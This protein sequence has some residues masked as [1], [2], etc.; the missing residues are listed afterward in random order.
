MKC[1]TSNIRIVFGSGCS[2]NFWL[3]P[4]YGPP[5]VNIIQDNDD[6][7]THILVLDFLHIGILEFSYSCDKKDP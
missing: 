5:F 3:D 1:V 4:W 7:N 6:I 2:I